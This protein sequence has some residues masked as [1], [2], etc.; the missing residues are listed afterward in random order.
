MPRLF[1]ISM[2]FKREASPRVQYTPSLKSAMWKDLQSMVHQEGVQEIED[3]SGMQ[4]S[5]FYRVVG[6]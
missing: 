3:P 2:A 1:P 5:R 6:E 4:D